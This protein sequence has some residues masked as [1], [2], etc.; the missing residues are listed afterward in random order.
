MSSV[1]VI[2]L[3]DSKLQIKA[4][5]RNETGH[6]CKIVYGSIRIISNTFFYKSIAFFAIPY[7]AT[8]SPLESKTNLL[9]VIYLYSMTCFLLDGF[10]QHQQA[11]CLCHYFPMQ[12][13]GFYLPSKKII[14]YRSDKNCPLVLT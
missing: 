6:N 11:H 2:V 7:A 10:Q 9:S 8:G 1:Q 5:V 3:H 12:L 14:L 4:R 13:L